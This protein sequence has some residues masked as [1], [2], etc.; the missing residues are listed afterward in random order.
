MKAVANIQVYRPWD[1]TV[2]L[3]RLR[4][5]QLARANIKT[6]GK[7]KLPLVLLLAPVAIATI[8]FAFVV[9]TRFSLEAGAT[10]AALGGSNGATSVLGATMMASAAH[11]LIETREMIV[12]FHLATDVFSLLLMAW[13]GAG[14]IA[15]DKRLG[16]HL[17]YFARPLTKLD[18]LLAKLCTVLFYGALGALLPGLLICLVAT[19]ASPDWSFL[20]EQGDVVWETIAFG[21]LW[22]LLVSSIVLCVSSLASRRTFALIGVFAWFLISGALSGI[23]AQANGNPSFRALSPFMASTR[24]AGTIFDLRHGVPNFDPGLAWISVGGSIVISLLVTWWR[25]R[26]L[27]VVA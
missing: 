9:Y 22:T 21:S 16:A 6:A 12:A 18:Y 15:E 7:R 19:F 14:L 17:L 4:W 13:F 23:L 1:G 25:V 2:R 20:T 3:T 8:I 27:E 11:Q 5:W 10:P 24:I 26:K